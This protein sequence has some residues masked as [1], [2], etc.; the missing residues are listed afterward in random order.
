MPRTNRDE[1]LPP[2]ENCYAHCYNKCVQGAYLCGKCSETGKDYSHRKQWIVDR[3]E[4]LASIYLI[5]ILAFSV[6]DNH[7]HVVLHTLPDEVDKQSDRDIAVRWLSLHPGRQLDEFVS[8]D[9]TE[10][11]I[12][13]LLADPERLARIRKN[14]SSAS[15]FMKDL[16][17]PISK[18]ANKEDG[19]SGHFWQDRFKAKRL[20]DTLAILV[21]VAYVDLNLMRAGIAKSLIDSKYTSI[22]ARI[23][24]YHNLRSPSLAYA[25]KSIS[26]EEA[27]Q[28]IKD[29][30]RVDR[31]RR[32]EF[33][34]L[35]ANRKWVLRDAWLAKLTIDQS[36]SVNPKTSHISRN[37][38]RATD[39]GFLPMTLPEYV[40][41]LYETLKF[42]PG[43]ASLESESEELAKLSKPFGVAPGNICWMIQ[44]YEK[45]FRHGNHVGSPE[46]MRRE[47]QRT[48]R[49]WMLHSRD[50]KIFY[51]KN[52]VVNHACD[53][54]HTSLS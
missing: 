24:G 1:V 41:I 54:K 23:L 31:R 50:V 35:D 33:S 44:D 12:Q 37:G 16:C 25:K 32:L 26:N 34:R 6:L 51:S 18:R 3:L 17:E 53:G 22:H 29:V 14:L 30:P 15:S 40:K 5:D 8:V 45:I 47:T 2:D 21:C 52:L 49:K 48:G 11:Q 10:A 39:R 42:R 4:Q 27:A 38:L 36:Q 19:R 20:L 7:L 13:Q 43:N 28:R 46:S 9:P